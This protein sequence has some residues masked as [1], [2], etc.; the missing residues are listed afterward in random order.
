MS[1]FGET[2]KYCF[3][4]LT[5]TQSNNIRVVKLFDKI[6]YEKCGDSHRL[7]KSLKVNGG[8]MPD[9]IGKVIATVLIAIFSPPL[10][11]LFMLTFIYHIWKTQPP[12]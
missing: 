4:K 7:F 11:I 10:F 12:E 6:I 8:N 3:G 1:R 2:K 9:F 5:D